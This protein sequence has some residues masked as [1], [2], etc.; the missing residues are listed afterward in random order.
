MRRKGEDVGAS[1]T[2]TETETET[3]WKK[4]VAMHAMGTKP[5]ITKIQISVPAIINGRCV[6]SLPPKY[7]KVQIV[8]IY[9]KD[10]YI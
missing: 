10:I 2:E 4:P 3:H 6:P 9:I 7:G 1:E 5:A 8:Y